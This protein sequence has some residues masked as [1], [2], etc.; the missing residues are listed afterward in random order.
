MLDKNNTFNYSLFMLYSWRKV[1]KERLPHWWILVPSNP[2]SLTLLWNY[3]DRKAAV[4]FQIFLMSPTQ[5]NLACNR[6]FVMKTAHPIVT[7]AR[8]WVL[9][10][11]DPHVN[12]NIPYRSSDKW[13]SVSDCPV[14]SLFFRWIIHS[15]IWILFW[16][17]SH[18]LF[19]SQSD[20]DI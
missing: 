7:A 3:L 16:K 12:L 1:I 18:S 4:E 5:L 15:C 8:S 9:T 20:K 6:Y 19:L 17:F 14:S 11:S 2:L 13:Q 10:D